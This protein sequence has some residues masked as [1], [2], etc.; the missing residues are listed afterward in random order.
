VLESD[1]QNVK[2]AFRMAQAL[3]E[4]QDGDTAVKSAFK[5]ISVAYNA[6]LS[7]PKIKELYSKIKDK[8]DKIQQ[9]N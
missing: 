5:W 3:W 7:D 2:C 1:P 6:Q 4:I 9:R 8:H